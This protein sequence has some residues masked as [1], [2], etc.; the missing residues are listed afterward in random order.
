MERI[1]NENTFSVHGRA[2]RVLSKL[3]EISQTKTNTEWFQN[4]WKIKQ[5]QTHNYREQT[6]G[7]R[8]VGGDRIGEVDEGD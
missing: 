6:G 8:A 7:V 5:I 2:Q 3:R 4:K 1:Q